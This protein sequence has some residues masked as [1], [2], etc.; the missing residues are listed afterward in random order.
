IDPTEGLLVMNFIPVGTGIVIPAT[1]PAPA[2]EPFFLTHLIKSSSKLYVST[3][4][5]GIYQFTLG[6]TSVNSPSATSLKM[7]LNSAQTELNVHA[8]SGS[9]ISIYSVTG[10]LLKSET[11]KHNQTS[12]AVNDLSASM[13]IVKVISENGQLSTNRFVK[14]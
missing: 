11:A 10:K 4:N 3:Y 13:Y 1:K 5:D 12:I 9:I 7:Y 6:A 8:Q 2:G 14:K